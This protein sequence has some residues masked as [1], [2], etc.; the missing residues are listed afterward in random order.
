ME[1]TVK[2]IDNIAIINYLGKIIY[3][4]RFNFTIINTKK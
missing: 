2:K 4:L 3:Q 1:V